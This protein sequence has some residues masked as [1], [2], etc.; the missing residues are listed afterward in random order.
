VDQYAI[1]RGR[2]MSPSRRRTRAF[3]PAAGI[4]AGAA[5]LAAQPPA[6]RARGL[7]AARARASDAAR[8][9]AACNALRRRWR[10]CRGPA[11]D[12]PLLRAPPP[13][14]RPVTPAPGE[15]A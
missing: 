2:A 10:A 4:G 9:R 14:P 7:A 8:A 12:H 5:M 6:Q 3:A 1:D 15:K 11:H 13:H